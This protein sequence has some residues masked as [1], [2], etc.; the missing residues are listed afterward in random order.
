MTIVPERYRQAH[1]AGFTMYLLVG[2]SPCSDRVVPS[3][4]C[5]AD[6]SE[7]EVELLVRDHPVGEGRSVLVAD[8]RPAGHQ[9]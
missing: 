7:V 3:R 8:I 6:G 1:V 2:R 4:R 9:G 5:G